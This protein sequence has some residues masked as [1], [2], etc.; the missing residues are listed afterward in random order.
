[1]FFGL[2][3]KFECRGFNTS[4]GAHGEVNR[5]CEMWGVSHSFSSLNGV[6]KLWKHI[7]EVALSQPTRETKKRHKNNISRLGFVRLILASFFYIYISHFVSAHNFLV[8]FGKWWLHT[9]ARLKVD[10]KL[11]TQ[12]QL[13]LE[14]RLQI[15]LHGHGHITEMLIHLQSDLGQ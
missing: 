9:L 11:P 5:V 10:T 2:R 3:A 4:T 1:M 12:T 7:R 13:R 8:K 6:V 15:V 14:I